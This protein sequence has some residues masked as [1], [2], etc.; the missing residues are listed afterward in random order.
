MQYRCRDEVTRRLIGSWQTVRAL[1]CVLVLPIA[2]VVANDGYYRTMMPPLMPPSPVQVNQPGF[3][4]RLQGLHAGRAGRVRKMVILSDEPRQAVL[5]ALQDPCTGVTMASY[6]LT[7]GLEAERAKQVTCVDLYF[8][9][10]AFSWNYLQSKGALA[11][12]EYSQ[13]WQLYHQCL[14]RLLGS[15]QRFGRLDPTRGLRVMT[16]MG[17]QTI[18]TSYNGFVWKTAD[19]TRVELPDHTA[20]QKLKH[21]Y[22]CP[23]LGVPLIVV[24]EHR[25]KERFLQDE[26]PFNATAILRP[27]LAAMAG[28]AP[29]VG[30]ASSHGPLEFYDPLRV[31]TV[32]FK[33][34][35]IA[36]A[37]DTSAA[38]EYAM[39]RVNYNPWAGVV[40]PGSADAGQE[41]LFMVEPYQP[42]KYPIV[43]V[44]GFYSS[45][46]IWA[47]FANEILARPELRDRIQLMAYRY[48][49][50]RPFLESAAILRREILAMKDKYDPRG[51][52]PGISNTMLIG[53][54]MGGLVSK[55]LVTYS[56]DR[57]WYSVAKRPLSEINVS[58]SQ[59][60][61]LRDM[62]YFE[63]VPFV[64]RVVFMGTP[65]GGAQLASQTLGRWGSK[66][67]QL[68]SAER[69]EHHLMIKQ[70]PCVF[71][72]E[73]QERI[74]TSIDLMEPSSC[75]LKTI[76]VLTVGPNVQLHN[77]VG[78]GLISPISGKGDGVVSLRSA[79]HHYVSTEKRIHTNHGGLH[80][81]DEAMKE[82]ECILRRHILE[83]NDVPSVDGYEFAVPET[84]IPGGMLPDCE[85]TCPDTVCPD[86]ECPDVDCPDV[87]CPDG[88]WPEELRPDYS[89]PELVIP[90]EEGSG[91]PQLQSSPAME[92]LPPRAGTT[93][94]PDGQHSIL[95]PH[96][97]PPAPAM[98]PLNVPAP[99]PA[100]V[101]PT[102]RDRRVLSEP[103]MAK[104]EME[105]PE[106]FSPEL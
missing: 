54:S 68:P 53:H 14:T 63:P 91:P 17:M 77:I 27:S 57:L 51:E 55:L 31:R 6:A 75:L 104:P 46:K 2:S 5:A 60:R 40:R 93:S 20:P 16:Q 19:F 39:R 10:V 62:F 9:G 38:L 100:S 37:T 61:R 102:R 1:M 7:A 13:A 23:G 86:L 64:R 25:A 66:H 34:Q 79:Q 67:V 50:G 81:R 69:I 87:D 28:Q 106:F 71:K 49:T 88:L 3:L 73:L 30:A 11:R 101:G 99:P 92:V 84:V 8:E 26:S 52:D 70:N 22:S 105:G 98:V 89:Y 29:P 74:P 95:V 36:M 47:H 32:K 78:V 33:K 82:I 21:H 45:P 76:R 72:P 90:T 96:A 24:R 35:R 56:D 94:A 18:P 65:H 4:N 103:E 42:G 41:K 59:R 80:E 97:T 43:F 44:H 58:D 85:E 48:P 83:A 12:P 15:A